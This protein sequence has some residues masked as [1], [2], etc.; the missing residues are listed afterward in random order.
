M[1]FF[2]H[3]ATAAAET[4]VVCAAEPADQ[5]MSYGQLVDC[6]LQVVGD[7]DLFRFQGSVGETISAQVISIG[8]PGQPLMQ[9]Y[10]PNGTLLVNYTTIFNRT[11]DTGGEYVIRVVDNFNDQTVQYRIAFERLSP[12]SPPSKAFSFGTNSDDSVDPAGDVDV[13]HFSGCVG[14]VVSFQI[15]KVSGPG[16]PLMQLFA[17]NGTLLVN[18]TTIFNR[19]LAAAGVHTVRV[20]DNFNDQPVDYRISPQRLVNNCGDITPPSINITSPTTQS[21][22]QTG[23]NTISLGGTASDNVAVTQVTWSNNRGGSGTATGTSV[24]TIPGITLA[25][26]ENVITVTARDAAGNQATDTILVNP[27]PYSFI[28]VTPCRVADTRVGEGKSGLFGPPFLAGGETREIPLPN[29][30]CGIPA[31]AKAYS[32]NFTVLPK[33]PLAYLTTWPAGVGIPLVS[34]LNSFHGGV[35]SNAAIVPAGTAGSVRVFVT[36]PTEVIIDVNGYFAETTG[37]NAF[38]FYRLAPCRVVDTRVGEGF[39]GM[40][41]PPV[42]AAAESRALPLPGSTRCSVPATARAYSLNATVVPPGPLSFLTL[43]PTG[44]AQPLVSTLN[45]FEGLIVANAAI[46]PGGTGAGINAFVTNP[47]EL[48]LDL[49]GYFA[50]P[51][52]GGLKFY[53]VT[54]C[55]LADT[56]TGQGPVMTGGSSRPFAVAGLCGIPNTAQAFSLN[57]TVVPNGPL[58]YLTLWPTGSG[59]PLVSTLNSFQGRIL[60]N[61]AIVPAGTNGS[62]SVFVTNTTDVILDINGYFA[63]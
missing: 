1:I 46:V 8:G 33:S 23:L 35:V 61:A 54:P 41:G 13:F 11:L 34:T 59:Q 42:M 17:P 24:W 60:A 56:R 29:S 10:A 53:P 45:S 16:Q 37:P 26:G 49:N 32:L 50:P 22:Y 6:Q 36:D 18:Y 30:G 3:G 15:V 25:A 5:A 7:V 4:P 19:T 21:T 58:S 31:N 39:T 57:V 48:I 51:A 20:V 55:R 44:S 28:P 27:A 62:V 47:T 9:L 40:F 2:V 63:P 12:P 43:F 38:D 52:A 14:D